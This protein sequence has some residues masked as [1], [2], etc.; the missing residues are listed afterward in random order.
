MRGFR[1]DEFDCH[2]IYKFNC[3]SVRG[4]SFCQH[5][6]VGHHR[7]ASETPFEWPAKRHLNGV[8]LTGRWWPDIVPGGGGGYTLIFSAYVGSDPASVLHPQNYQEFQ[9]PQKNIF[10][11]LATQ[12]NI[13]NSVP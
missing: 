8:S 1:K 13:P 9:A 2:L 5:L 3:F 11:I 10:E 4:E 6:K 7:S 12:K